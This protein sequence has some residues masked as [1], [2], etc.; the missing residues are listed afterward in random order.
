MSIYHVIAAFVIFAIVIFVFAILY[1]M[2][3]RRKI[4][5]PFRNMKEYAAGIAEGNFDRPAEDSEKKDFGMFAESFD[6]ILSE[7]ER[8]RQRETLLLEKQRDFVSSLGHELKT[9][10]TGIMLTSEKLRTGLSED[11]DMN[12]AKEIL[13]EKL[14]GIY[15][16]AAQ[17]DEL[18]TQLET[19]ALDD[20]GEV[21]INL[22]DEKAEVLGDIVKKH[23]DRRLV[24]MSSIPDVLIH[25]DAKR[26]SQV[27]GNIIVN[28]YRYA[29]TLI[30]VSFLLADDFLQMTIADHGPGVAT[31]E[32]GHITDR[33]Y[34]SRLGAGSGEG[35]GLGLYTAR[36]LMKKMGGELLVANTG[37]GL[38][39]TLLI[40]LS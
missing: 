25:I 39:I 30:D 4:I 24:I 11:I 26:M 2:Y 15:D 19:A 34:R 23:D 17:M 35:S 16:K 32:I 8:S 10:V 27:I 6:I 31:D 7:L 9:P 13:S 37:D 28:S 14:E 36:M 40:P 20:L 38:G 12:G 5:I 33:F 1:G 29:D 18:I 21:R 3:L 22:A